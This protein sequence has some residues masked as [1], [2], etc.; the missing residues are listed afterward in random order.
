[1]LN[2]LCPIC[3]TKA[4]KPLYILEEGKL[5][6]CQRCRLIF[7]LPRPT[8][9]SLEQY[10]N[11][12]SYSEDYRASSMAGYKFASHRYQQFEK[13]FGQYAPTLLLANSQV[14]LDIGCGE[15][16]FLSIAESKG[17]KVEGIELSRTS[18]QQAREKINGEVYVGEITTLD[19]PKAKYDLITSYHV[20]EHLIDPI[21]MLQQIYELLRPGG[22]VLIETPNIGSLGARIRGRKWSHIIP[23]EHINYFDQNT[24]LSSLKRAGFK[25][26][27]IYTITP[28]TIHSI[29]N[30]PSGIKQLARGLYRIAPYFNLGASLQAIAVR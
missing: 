16:D 23:P 12:S 29:S 20:I 9:E 15:G 25:S 2:N 17:W 28:H 22:A 21:V 8:P 7:Y 18:A 1:M 30:F 24:L 14:L 10:Y 11:A 3:Q 26:I 4:H 19:L 6:Q 27:Y 13:A 5:S